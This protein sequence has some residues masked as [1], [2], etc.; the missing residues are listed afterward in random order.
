MTIV[1]VVGAGLAGLSA[2]LELGNAG[3]SCR[4][5]SAQASERAQSVLAEGG[6]NAVLDLM[7]EHDTLRE[8]F[9]DTM[10]GG[11][12]LADPNAVWGLVSDAPLIVRRLADLGVPFQQ[13]HGAMIQRNFGGQKKKRTAY[14]K[15]ST[16]KV[17]VSALVDAVRRLE[18]KGVV[19]RAWHH[20]LMDLELA[21]GA[22]EGVWV[23]DTHTGALELLGGPTVLACGGMGGLFGNLTTGTTTNTGNAAAIALARG[24]ELANLEFLQYHPTTMPLSVKRMLVTEAARGEGGRLF[25]LRRGEPWYFMEDKYPE[26]GNLMPRD[27]VSRE[28]EAV[29]K[30]PSCGGQ[31][32]LDMRGLSAHVWRTRLSDLRDE[33]RHYQHLDPAKEPLPVEP[34]IHYCMGGIL[35]DE[36]HRTNVARLYAAGECACAYHGA[37]RLGGNSLLGAIR[38]GMVAARALLD[39]DVSAQGRT[40]T[41][42]AV[43]ADT[44]AST[45]A[46]LQTNTND[47]ERAMQ[48]AL[49]GCMGI[50]RTQQELEAGLR[51]LEALP[52]TAR[53]ALARA[54]VACALARQESR[55][56]HQRSDYPHTSDDFRRTTVV[57]WQGDQPSIEFRALPEPRKEVPQA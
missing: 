19:T 23:R 28:E 1:N 47:V 14:V 33:V 22:C 52:H 39:E 51:S 9:E 49:V 50:T 57:R 11:A 44:P 4:L 54:T 34:G 16:G 53:V 32:Y 30:D 2:A 42:A 13:E 27:V 55:G 7:G 36:R 31:V 24:V 21:D 25:A 5:V 8:H 48:K 35:V 17:L 3:V 56:A 15:S 29:L 43:S 6:I 38:G 12:Y 40:Q 18:D 26:L 10:R 20:E 41:R 37:N 46:S 45:N